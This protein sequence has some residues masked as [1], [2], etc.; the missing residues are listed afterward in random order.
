[1]S[2]ILNE[3]RPNNDSYML[4]TISCFE[5]PIG[6]A[7]SY[8]NEI[9]SNY[10]YMFIEL[11]KTYNVSEYKVDDY[12]YYNIINTT[13]QLLQQEFEIDF[14]RIETKDNISFPIQKQLNKNNP[15]L[16]AGN[17]YG[18]Y[19]TKHYKTNNWRHLFLIKGY[20]ETR[21][22]YYILD[23]LQMSLDQGKYTDYFMPYSLMQELYNLYSFFEKKC[24]FYFLER[25]IS[26]NLKD[27]LELMLNFMNMYLN[28]LDKQPYKE[29]EIIDEINDCIYESIH[30]N[31]AYME[32]SSKGGHILKYLIPRLINTPKCKDVMFEELLEKLKLLDYP[33]NKIDQISSLKNKLISE[34]TNV[35]NILIKDVY[36][37]LVISSDQKL[38]NVIAYEKEMRKLIAE[39]FNFYSN[40]YE[41]HPINKQQDD[42]FV[43]YYCDNNSDNLITIFEKNIIFN[44]NTKKTY[45]TWSEDHCPKFLFK[46]KLIAN[47]HYSL[48]TS[49]K[50]HENYKETAYHA[51]II[52]MTENNQMYLWGINSGLSLRLDKVGIEN[53]I[54]F[55]INNLDTM[56]FINS[57]N[58][59]CE[60]GYIDEE[61]NKQ[62]VVEEF[63]LD[64]N[65]KGLG[66]GCKT[67]GNGDELV[68]KFSNC[69]LENDIS[70]DKSN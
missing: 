2:N 19:Y 50:V 27:N 67:W 48:K 15:V 23:S 69:T 26:F 16:I 60:V 49:I 42:N 62:H 24:E 31:S 35:I 9:Y 14:N 51:G 25:Q 28:K 17:S 61:I 64:S 65:I 47:K 6:I 21:Q 59:I 1:M 29:L 46:D 12:I 36:N 43:N 45:N 44:F 52:I 56:L 8:Y 55:P 53:I 68:I 54:D 34:W 70:I 39:C 5:K 37:H 41:L 7:M 58:D 3:I 66:I 30:T 40:I 33:N 4:D 18:L 32:T 57:Y 38:T 63:K 10:Y 11:I 22:L 13:Q 20:D